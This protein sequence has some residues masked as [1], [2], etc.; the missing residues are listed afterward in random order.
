MNNRINKIH[1]IHIR[2][3]YKDNSSTFREDNSVSIHERNIQNFAIEL[4]KVLNVF[5][6]EL[7]YIIFPINENM[8]YCLKLYLRREMS[9][10]LHMAQEH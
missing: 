1:K 7:M 10:L 9:T 5:S 6:A 3:V 2:V 4:Y 8:L